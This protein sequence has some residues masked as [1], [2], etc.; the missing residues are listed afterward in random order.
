M[1][2]RISCFLAIVLVA[3][4]SSPSGRL[5]RMYASLQKD[6][7]SAGRPAGP[8][9]SLAE[10]H[11]ERAAE[12]RE[13]I[14]KG[15]VTSAEDRFRA[16]VLLVE[17]DDLENLHLA[18]T[19]GMQAGNAGAPLGFRVAAEAIDKQAVIRH[20]PQRYGTQYE[21]V[22]VLRAWRLYP[23]DPTT[24]DEQRRTM[25]VPGLAELHEGEKRM[26]EL[27]RAN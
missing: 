5:A 16:A 11:A 20:Q 6:V 18:E 8:D 10:R 22:P 14:E 23:V 3:G 17:T 2:R 27:L 4:C 9:E 12:V 7:A 26:N 19:L 25:G 21:W 1:N 24:T 15:E 13:M